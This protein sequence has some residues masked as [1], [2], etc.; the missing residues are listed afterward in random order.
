MLNNNH[1]NHYETNTILK[2]ENVNLTLGDNHILDDINFEIKDIKEDGAIRGQI[3]GLIGPSGVGKTQLLKIIAGLNTPDTGSVLVA[4]DDKATLMPVKAGMVGVVAQNYPLFEHLSVLDNLIL[5]GT[6]SK[7]AKKESKEKAVELLNRF[8]LEERASFWPAQLS[9]GQRQRIAILQQLM[10]ER[11]FL[12]MDEPF[13]GLDPKAITILL[14]FISEVANTNELNTIII[15]SHDIRSVVISADR[16]YILGRQYD[17]KGNLIRSAHITEEIDLLE[18]G[19]A[20]QD[21]IKE[22][23]RFNSLV[24]E[25]EEK[26]MRI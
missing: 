15:I 22:L 11:Y 10:V 6:A 1:T 20:W 21:K 25:I 5:A 26:F 17:S 24:N 23:P 13:S 4:V 18:M 12:I 19:L 14:D 16:I 3:R 2:I 8:G 7:L 9:G